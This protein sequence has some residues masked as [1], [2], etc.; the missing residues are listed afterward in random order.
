M[1]VSASLWDPTA[2]HGP[3]KVATLHALVAEEQQ[4]HLLPLQFVLATFASIGGRMLEWS[5]DAVP[6]ALGY[7]LPASA[8]DGT[9][10][11]LIG[12]LP[13]AHHSLP[14]PD[15]KAAVTRLEPAEEVQLF[16]IAAAGHWDAPPI[17][18]TVAGI[19]YGRPRVQD[20][21]ALRQLQ[22]RIWHA[23]PKNLYPTFLHHP[24]CQAAWS[25]VARAAD[26]VVGFLIGFRHRGHPPTLPPDWP[27]PN[28]AGGVFESQ[29][30][31]V[32]PDFRQ[33]NIAFHLKRLQAQ[34]LQRQGITHVQWTADPLQYRNARLNCN[35]LG[36]VGT[37][38]LPDYLPFRNELNQVAASR[39]RLVWPLSAAPAQRALTQGRAFGA[40][41]LQAGTALPQVHDNLQQIRLHLDAP[42]LAIEIPDDWTRMQRTDRALAQTWRDTTD[43][44]LAHYLG[45]APGQ[46]MVTHTGRRGDRCYLVATQVGPDLGRHYGP[47][48]GALH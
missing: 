21:H 32:H 43:T 42:C 14:S 34:E 16:D 3:T 47:G 9:P 28:T 1:P 44:I 26:R 41:D 48:T 12:Y 38:L 8:A 18:E 37:R 7:S 11:R 4:R 25:L 15:L 6:V 13:V 45:P 10:Y 33:Q 17:L 35:R 36:A 31:G 2:P 19:A 30:L 24:R 39:L 20:A 29:T 40:P 46:Y 27:A 22:A 5:L 23:Q